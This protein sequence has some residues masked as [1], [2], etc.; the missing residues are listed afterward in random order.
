MYSRLQ[1]APKSGVEPFHSAGQPL[2]F[3]V[4]SFWRWSA[5]DLASNA[6][7]G[8][9]AEFLVARAIGLPPDDLRAEWDAYDLRMPGTGATIE[10]KS[11][12]YLQTWAQTSPTTVCFGVQPTRAWSADTN[13]MEPA[14][15]RRRQA[16]LYVFA[17]LHHLEKDTLDPLD[18]SQWTFYVLPT[19]VL[20]AAVPEQKQ[21][22][23]P[24][25]RRLRPAQCTFDAL[26]A[27]IAQAAQSI[28]SPR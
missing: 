12:A 26:G 6:Q 17:V 18:V 4:L 20:D 14:S 7:R 28:H 1:V 2:G 15:A 21:I 5:S 8:R 25:L 9:V 23:L 16:D 24:A 19:A 10:V 13:A 3:D 22:T 11:S 27:S